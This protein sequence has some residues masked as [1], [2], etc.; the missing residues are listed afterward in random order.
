MFRK[1]GIR[2][3]KNESVEQYLKRLEEDLNE[4]KDWYFVSHRHNFGKQTMANTMNDIEWEVFDM[5]AKYSYLSMEQLLC[6]DCWSRND[7]A[8]FNYGVCPYFT[9]CSNRSRYHLYLRLFQMREIRYDE[10]QA[11]L[12]PKHAY[13]LVAKSKMKG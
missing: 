2:V 12:S 5:Y 11:E 9:L 1:P 7:R 8:C 4:R 6:P 13:S 10:E 3:K